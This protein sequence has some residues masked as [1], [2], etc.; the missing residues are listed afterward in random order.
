MSVSSRAMRAD[1]VR[2][3]AVKSGA[4]TGDSA[5]QDERLTPPDLSVYIAAF[6]GFGAVCAGG[7]PP[8][9]GAEP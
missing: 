7:V 9:A 8:V 3:G 2:E 6:L 5:G 1:K 4:E